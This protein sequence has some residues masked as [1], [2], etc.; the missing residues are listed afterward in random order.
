VYGSDPSG[1][2]DLVTEQGLPKE[3]AD[4]CPAYTRRLMTPWYELLS[5][6]MAK[7]YQSTRQEWLE[8]GIKGRQAQDKNVD[9]YVR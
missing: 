9:Q 2:L 8:Q 6:H 7:K 1:F 5:P 4:T 3:R